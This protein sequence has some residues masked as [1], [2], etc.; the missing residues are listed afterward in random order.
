[1]ALLV[2]LSILAC[3]LALCAA[4]DNPNLSQLIVIGVLC[5]WVLPAIWRL[6]EVRVQL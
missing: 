4:K 3:L 1:M 5:A 6:K 2:N